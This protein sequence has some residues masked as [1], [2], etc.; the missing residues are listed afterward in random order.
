MNIWLQHWT[1]RAISAKSFL[2]P[3]ASADAS[4][5]N[6]WLK[7]LLTSST[8]WLRGK[9]RCCLHF[10]SPVYHPGK[11]N[12]C[13]AVLL[14][15]LVVLVCD[16]VVDSSVW[17]VLSALCFWYSSVTCCMIWCMSAA[18]SRLALDCLAWWYVSVSLYYVSVSLYY[19]IYM[20]VSR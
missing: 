8:N 18:R 11:V 10:R 6:R 9:G 20:H 4:Q 16:F 1:R 19:F 7:L 17:Y 3:D 13:S 5:A 12:N 14:A 15:K 2:W